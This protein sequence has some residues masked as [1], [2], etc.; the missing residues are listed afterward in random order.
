M[1]NLA[2]RLNKSATPEDTRSSMISSNATTE[3]KGYEVFPLGDF[4]L[5]SGEVLPEAFIAYRTF[6]DSKNPAIINPTW[7]SGCSSL[8]AYE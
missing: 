1:E 7:Y 3:D 6:G 5:D 2:I 8:R 4:Q